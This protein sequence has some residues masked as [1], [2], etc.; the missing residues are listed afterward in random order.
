MSAPY[1]PR[2]IEP[3]APKRPLPTPLLV[4]IV[5]GVA[6][7]LVFAA[8][9]ANLVGP[10]EAHPLPPRGS[11]QP[12]PSPR[13]PPDPA[14]SLLS[15]IPGGGSLA[16]W[17]RWFGLVV[18]ILLVA[19]ALIL[20]LRIM[21]RRRARNNRTEMV[22]PLERPGRLS[23]SHLSGDSE[24]DLTDP[25][26]FQ[27]RAAADDIIASWS[28]VEKAVAQWGYTRKAWTT[29]TEFLAE[30]T[31]EFGNPVMTFAADSSVGT[32]VLTELRE[33]NLTTG[34]QVLLHF[35][36]RARFDTAR[37]APG[38]ATAART[39]ARLVLQTWDDERDRRYRSAEAELARV[40]A[41]I[42][43]QAEL[44]QVPTG[45]SRTERDR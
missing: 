3:P 41:E 21:L 29:P 39:A 42:A 10:L 32:P 26:S 12:A 14:F 2:T 25:R 19:V 6:V 45:T 20:A 30:L 23:V 36:H 9:L 15:K 16:T 13:V 24:A 40:S 17:L 27:A 11:R 7:A 43:A 34:A 37:L 28:A 35:Y 44:E 1:R 22:A 38:A 31:A 4:M 8:L 33:V 18:T 5:A